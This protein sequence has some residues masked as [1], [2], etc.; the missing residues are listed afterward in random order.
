MITHEQLRLALTRYIDAEFVQKVPGLKKWLVV[1]AV[2]EI[3]STFDKMMEE[4]KEMLIARSYMHPNG[5]I[6]IDRVYQEIRQIAHETGEVIEH[7][8]L[9]GDV[10]FSVEDI[11]KL[12][13]MI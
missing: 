4:N 8:P 3:L 12:H 5:M 1:L 13:R 7:L 11:D 10:K 9:F 6:D 2:P